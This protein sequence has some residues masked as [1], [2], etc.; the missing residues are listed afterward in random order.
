MSSHVKHKRK[1]SKRHARKN[2]KRLPSSPYRLTRSTLKELSSLLLDDPESTTK[3]LALA[4]LITGMTLK[5]LLDKKIKF[6]LT[7]SGVGKIYSDWHFAK[8]TSPIFDRAEKLVTHS[9]NFILLPPVIAKHIEHARS[10]QIPHKVLDKRIRHLLAGKR[11]TA[12]Q[13]ITLNSLKRVIDFEFN[14]T[15]MTRFE[16]D[17]IAQRAMNEHMQNFYVAFS[18]RILISH[19][20]E[21]MRIFLPK[22]QLIPCH[23]YQVSNDKMFG[24]RKA[25]S[26][27]GVRYIFEQISTMLQDAIVINDRV[28]MHNIYTIY[29]VTILQLATMHRPAKDV[30]RTIHTFQNDFSQVEILDKSDSSIRLVPLCDTAKTVLLEYISYLKGYRNR[31]RFLSP[32]HYHALDD[33]LQGLSNL[34]RIQTSSVFLPGFDGFPEPLS[35]KVFSKINWHRH[36]MS[37]FLSEAGANRDALMAMMG[38]REAL[39]APTR[40]SS[41]FQYQQLLDISAEIDKELK[42]LALPDIQL[43]K[44]RPQG[45]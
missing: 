39:D 31:Y 22:T 25:L 9:D 44:F 4:I 5:Q 6:E 16:R 20:L 23:H 24:S 27:N 28:A 37:S 29:V 15:K 12:G 3:G 36:T 45:G 19:H 21:F 2:K 42:A 33:M 7:E 43:T 10:Q 26:A 8:A 18:A 40:W 13:L 35:D 11:S 1:Y 38:H 14:T 32:S 34:F 17:F 30:F 41:T